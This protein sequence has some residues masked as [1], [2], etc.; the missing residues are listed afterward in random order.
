MAGTITYSG[1]DVMADLLSGQSSSYANAIAVGTGSA[2]VSRDDTSLDNEV[3]RKAPSSISTT[4]TGEREYTI[5]ITGGSEVPAGT[6][7]TEFGLFTSTQDNSGDLVY[8]E[9][10]TPI[11]V[12]DGI[13]QEFVLTINID[14]E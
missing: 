14:I 13:T 10:A 6:E 11:T 7:I 2:N 3:H 1:I 8:R 4:N 9:V 12:G 5:S